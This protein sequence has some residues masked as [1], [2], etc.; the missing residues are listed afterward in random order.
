ME[1]LLKQLLEAVRQPAIPVAPEGVPVLRVSDTVSKAVRTYEIVRNTLEYDDEHL[2]RRNAIRR[3]LKRRLG[4]ELPLTERASSLLR[5]LIWAQY[6]PN[7]R[8][9][10]TMVA[11]IERVLAKY[12]KLVLKVQ[13]MPRTG[14][15]LS[16]VLDL[17]SS[18]I[19]YT[20]APPLADEALASFAYTSLRSRVSWNSRLIP[21]GDRDLQLFVAIH[22]AMLK[23]NVAT[24]R[25]RVLTL[26]HPTWAAAGPDDPVVSHVLE[27]LE[28][29]AH[30]IE[31]QLRHPGAESLFR[32]VR[33]T[34]FLF[35]VLR[36]FLADDALSAERLLEQGDVPVL[37]DALSKTMK[38]RY[39]RFHVRLRRAVL[40]A[41]LFLF[42]TKFVFALLIE[43]PYET[44]ILHTKDR[45]P[46]LVNILFHPL[47]LG[48]IG[49]TVRIPE[50]RNTQVALSRLHA[51][52]GFG[53]DEFV[54]SYEAKA[55]RHRRATIAFDVLYI[56]AFGITIALIVYALS[57]LHFTIVSTALFLFFLSLVTFFGLKI[58][59]TR[60]DLLVVESSGGLLGSLIDVLFLPIIRLGRWI[61]MRAP[62]VNIFLFFLDMFIEAPIKSA[63][64]LFEGWL[65]FLKEKKEEI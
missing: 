34:A 63:S 61:A 52:L 42:M 7:E 64:A 8:I 28:E 21:E 13:G 19:E 16:W 18:E 60:R 56:L 37:D 10:E 31:S 3:I 11:T 2:L 50:K 44:Y 29:T 62:R 39:I 41:V 5:E 53:K 27:R 48:L 35:H 23:S 14:E 51:I 40:R 46:L 54:L 49:I 43:L 47:F 15:R 59:H 12:D 17:W 45:N 9:P 1:R 58:R 30:L 57:H 65:S 24:L 36:D 25:Y 4:E 26:Y 6:L 33:R 32:L 38:R 55:R 22:R 20:I